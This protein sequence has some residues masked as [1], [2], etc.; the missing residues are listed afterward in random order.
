MLRKA[1]QCRL[2]ALFLAFLG[3]S[4]LEEAF[5]AKVFFNTS[6]RLER[7]SLSDTS[8]APR[9]LVPV[10]QGLCLVRKAPSSD[11]LEPVL[12]SEAPGKESSESSKTQ[13]LASLGRPASGPLLEL[14]Q[15]TLEKGGAGGASGAG[16]WLLDLSASPEPPKGSDLGAEGEWSKLRSR[17]GPSVMDALAA[18]DYAALLSTAV[19]LSEWHRS[20]PF[21]AKCG[22]RTAPFRA[23]LNRRCEA[24]GARYRPRLDPSVIVLVTHKKRCLLGRKAVWPPGRYS[25]LAGF[26]EFGETLEECVV[27]EVREESGVSVDPSSIRFVASQPWLFPRSLMMGFI[28]EAS[29]PSLQLDAEELE[30]VGWFDRATLQGALASEEACDGT[31]ASLNVPSRASLANTLM[32][33]WLRD[34]EDETGAARS[35]EGWVVIVSGVHEEAQEDDIFEAF[36]EYGDIKNLHLNL[37]RRTGFVKGYAFIEYENKQEA[38]AAIK[39]MDGN[40]LLDHK[41]DVSWAF[42]KPGSKK[43][44]R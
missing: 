5:V 4:C 9:C 35:I 27:R 7:G 23:G 16:F 11:L 38:D 36:S 44:R 10:Y 43:K 20:V 30:D 15:R 39:G 19:G 14:Q 22:G 6:G 31:P 28:A 3:L 8:E 2:G 21:C 1:L 40:T 17:S 13:F 25:T 37:D 42:A 24:C 26:V 32:R 12:L 33:T 18:D 41:L 34:A 29:D